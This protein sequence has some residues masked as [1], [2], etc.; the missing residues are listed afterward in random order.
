M[1]MFKSNKLAVLAALLSL[2][3]LVSMLAVV[4]A[5]AEDATTAEETTVAETVEA[6]EPESSEETEAGTSAESSTEKGTEAST[7]EETTTVNKDELEKAK[8]RRI[9][10]YINL[11]VGAVIL[12]GLAVLAF[13]FRAKIPAWWKGLKSECGKITWCPKDKLKK[14]VFVVI[15]IIVAIAAAIGVLDFV[16]SRGMILLGELVH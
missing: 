4:P 14:N 8:Q 15:I 12:I 11:G 13:V 10:G 3:M 1:N 7:K 5:F 9:R 6:T 16:F 2:L